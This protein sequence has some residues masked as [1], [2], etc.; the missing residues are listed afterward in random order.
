MKIKK[1]NLLKMK[2]EVTESENIKYLGIYNE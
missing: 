2:N 1:N